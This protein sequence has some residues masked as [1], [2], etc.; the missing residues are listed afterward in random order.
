MA[1]SYPNILVHC[2]FSTRERQ[3]SIPDELQ[4]SL[5]KYIAGIGINHGISVL[6]CGGTRNH[7]HILMALP[8]DISLSKA[9]Q[10]I[11]ANSS[12]WVRDQGVDFAWQ[13]GYGAFSVSASHVK[14]VRAYIRN[15]AEHHKKRDFEQEFV[16]H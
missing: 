7:A 13:E 1:H 15:Q 10:I 4:P 11:K 14:A 8:A 6:E 2:V 9:V 5:W 3:S 12:R 16:T